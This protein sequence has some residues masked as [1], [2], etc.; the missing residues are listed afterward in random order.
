[1]SRLVMNIL[2]LST[3][4]EPFCNFVQSQALESSQ[5][6][7]TVNVLHNNPTVLLPIGPI[8]K[9]PHRYHLE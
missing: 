4:L 9:E 7:E 1:M 3:N 2:V 6:D 8:A 5:F